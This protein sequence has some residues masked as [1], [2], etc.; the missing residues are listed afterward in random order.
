MPGERCLIF[1]RDGSILVT[2]TAPGAD[3]ARD[4]LRRFAELVQSAGAYHTYRVTPISL[5]S[6]AAT[7]L[8]ASEIL[9]AL[10]RFGEHPPPASL[11]TRVQETL[12][13]YGVLRLTGALGRLRLESSPPP[14]LGPLAPAQSPAR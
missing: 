5:W 12:A 9:G 2:A 11:A 13:R 6:A 1:Q 3:E 7:G 10:D 4:L 14:Q 8:S